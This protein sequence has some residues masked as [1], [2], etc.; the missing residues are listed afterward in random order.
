MNNDQRNILGVYTVVVDSYQAIFGLRHPKMVILTPYSLIDRRYRQQIIFD[1]MNRNLPSTA[2]S[3]AV[4]SSLK[5]GEM[6]KA[7]DR[8]IAFKVGLV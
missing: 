1:L 2:A 8:W 4:F 3:M 7:G 6:K 5:V